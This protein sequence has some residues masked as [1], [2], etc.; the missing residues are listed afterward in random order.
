M[1]PCLPPGP[2]PP[3]AGCGSQSSTTAAN[4]ITVFAAS[5]LTES[6][7]RL[8]QQ[9]EAANPGAT[10]TFSFAASSALATQ[11]LSGAPADVFAS[12]STATMQ[13][14]VDS[15]AVADPTEFA[16]NSMA[17]AVPPANPGKVTG[18]DSLAN[19]SVKTAVCQP[20]VP[21]GVTAQQV[22][23]NAGVTVSPVTLEPDVKSVLSKVVLGEVDAGLV[24]ATD[25]RAAGASVTGIDIPT[26]VNASTAYPIAAVTTS[27]NTATARDF[28][29]YVLSPAGQR[30]LAAAG[31]GPP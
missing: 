3:A 23:G 1:S 8:G 20:Q 29:E 9:Y 19:R 15:G 6:F 11:I 31:F 26:A 14:V 16:V 4:S 12:A 28:V 7:S 25:V 5:S 17:I 30:V 2:A 21:C 13:Q 22:F 27:R 10:V 24:Y 18:L